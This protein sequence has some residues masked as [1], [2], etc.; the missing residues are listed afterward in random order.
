MKASNIYYKLAKQKE[1][2]SRGSP[3][4]CMC[5][6]KSTYIHIYFQPTHKKISHIINQ[7]KLNPFLSRGEK[8][9]K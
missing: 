5:S 4:S 7:R 9:P 3:S 6:V 8:K 2:E 1:L